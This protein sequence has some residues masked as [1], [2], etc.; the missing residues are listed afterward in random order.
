[1][2][3][4]MSPPSASDTRSAYADW[5]E[6]QVIMSTRDRAA[7]ATITNVLDFTDDLKDTLSSEG[8][9]EDFDEAIADTSKERLAEMLFDELEYRSQVLG[10][11]Y[12]FKIDRERTGEPVLSRASKAGAGER[13]QIVYLFCLLAAALRDDKL[14]PKVSF[15]DAEKGIANNF[16]TCACLAAGGFLGGE[17]ASFGWPRAN[18]LAFLPALEQTYKRFGVGHV[19]ERIDEGLPH[20]LKDGGIDIIAW[21]NHP[22]TMPGKLYLIGQCAS[23]KQWREKSVTEFIGQLHGTWFTR[24]PQ[25]HVMPAMF[26]PFTFHA[27]LDEP[28][29]GNFVQALH[30]SHWS[31]EQRFGIIFDRLR[32]THYAGECLERHEDWLARIDGA[33]KFE[34]VRAWVNSTLSAAG[35][36][37]AAA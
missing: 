36:Q 35:I 11:A 31:M 6:F 33:D 21:R 16:Q 32:I 5:L 24:A 18:G 25:K 4:A 22:D 17:V 28:K 34:N 26:I 14:Q 30:N 8:E 12:P 15:S 27:D 37:K 7:M 1:M 10:Q 2:N 23:G 19:R 3:V 29:E 9:S 13:G 20:T